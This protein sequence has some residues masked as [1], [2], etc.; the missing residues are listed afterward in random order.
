[1]I[2][3][4]KNHDFSQKKQL[5]G[6]L[7]PK[8]SIWIGLQRDGRDTRAFADGRTA[9]GAPKAPGA[10]PHAVVGIEALGMQGFE[11]NNWDWDVIFI[12]FFYHFSIFVN[13]LTYWFV[14]FYWFFFVFVCNQIADFFAIIPAWVDGLFLGDITCCIY[15]ISNTL[16]IVE[17]QWRSCSISLVYAKFIQIHPNSKFGWSGCVFEWRK[18][19]PKY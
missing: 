10:E 5:I 13:W 14:E 7:E 11:H 4:E 9:P 18:G 15:Y 12:W 16:A 2:F 17:D 1:M 6:F 3:N 8:I 19:C